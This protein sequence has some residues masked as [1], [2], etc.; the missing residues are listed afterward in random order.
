[1]YS[2]K[3]LNDLRRNFSDCMR[4]SDSLHIK[5]CNFLSSL[6]NDRAHEFMVHGF[7][8]RS[9]TLKRCIENIYRLNPPERVEKL[10]SHDR[11]DLQINL[12]AF[13][14]NVFGAL[15]NLALVTVHELGIKILPGRIGFLKEKV[16][17]NLAN[18]LSKEFR[19]YITSLELSEWK[20]YMRDFRHALGHRIPLYVPPSGLNKRDL[21]RYHKIEDQLAKALANF[22]VKSHQRLVNKQS[23]LG[24]N[25]PVVTHSF[26][27]RSEQVFFHSQVL[28]DF[29]TVIAIAIKFMDEFDAFN[30]GTKPNND[31]L[32]NVRTTCYEPRVST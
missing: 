11:E 23:S 22:D 16:D 17:E 26:S 4:A 25:F 3:Q 7:L 32:A 24:R 19:N 14:F 20:N 6:R 18:V 15:D 21:K 5:G 27:E 9:A 12:Q 13:V 31:K 8:R 29:N 28:T 30:N 1:M 2:K 10:L